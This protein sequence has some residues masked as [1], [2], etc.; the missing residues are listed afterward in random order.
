MVPTYY[1][2]ND[3]VC[4]YKDYYHRG[5]YS[6][7]EQREVIPCKY[8]F[9][10]FCFREGLIPININDKYGF[11]N[12]QCEIAIQ[13]TYDEASWFSE[14]FA[15]VKR[16]GKEGYVDRYGTDTFSFRE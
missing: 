2:K 4:A 3:L 16:Y 7:E 15:R 14:G 6:I 8:H 1:A 10:D 9:D 11:F 13:P 12:K 5:F